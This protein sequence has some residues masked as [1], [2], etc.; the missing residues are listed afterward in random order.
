MAAG[1]AR[2][3]VRL[4]ICVASVWV[5]AQWPQAAGSNFYEKGSDVV[6]LKT[7]ADFRKHVSNSSFLWVLQL[8]R[9]GCGFCKLLEA[10]YERAA[11][12]LKHIVYFGAIDVE[13]HP[14]LSAAV[15]KKYG[16]SV[17]GVPTV[18][19]VSPGSLTTQDYRG[20][21]KAKDLKSACYREMPSFVEAVQPAALEKWLKKGGDTSR[22]AVLFSTKTTVTPLLKAISSAYRGRIDFAQ[23]AL[24]DLAGAVGKAWADRFK[25]TRLPALVVLQRS[26]DDHEGAK[27]VA[28]KFGDRGFAS[29]TWADGEKPSFRK[30]EGWLMGYGRVAR[31]SPPRPRARSRQ[32]PGGEL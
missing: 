12:D 10:E 9:E 28:E 15:T 18:R 2:P 24:P 17:E 31:T 8:Y 14:Q 26:A 23:V 19:L 13:R 6:P 22:R 5:L 32:K 1:G 25:L 11:T 21:R 16:F 4:S 20:E 27:W 29:L 30:M 3:S 7:K